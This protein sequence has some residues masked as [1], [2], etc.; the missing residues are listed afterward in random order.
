M[1]QLLY[2]LINLAIISAFIAFVLFLAHTK[3]NAPDPATKPV[4][5]K[6]GWCILASVIG[7]LCANL[8]ASLV[9][10]MILP[11]C[12]VLFITVTIGLKGGKISGGIALTTISLMSA[13]YWVIYAY[14]SIVYYP[15]LGGILAVIA[16]ILTVPAI[17]AVYI[18]LIIYTVSNKNQKN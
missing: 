14:S 9:P 11:I 12:V 8:C 13:I 4:Y 7:F 2:D 10:S 6:I 15:N 3:D 17:I 1:N 5:K 18:W 16:N